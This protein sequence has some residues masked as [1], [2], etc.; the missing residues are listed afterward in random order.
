LDSKVDKTRRILLAQQQLHRIEQ[1]RMAELERRL[2][3][4][5]A[6]QVDLIGALNDTNALHGLFIDTTA[7]RLSST[8][9]QAER[10]A[11]EKEVQSLKVKEHA[12]RVK[13]SERLTLAHEQEA[14]REQEAKE[15]LDIVEQA[16]SRKRTSLP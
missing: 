14:A 15:L 4:L 11:R 1:W 8:A 7:R 6:L 9:E 3:E 16:V 2:A 5:E 12:V 13:I 10:V